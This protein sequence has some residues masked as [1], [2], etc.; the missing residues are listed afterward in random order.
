MKEEKEHTVEEE[1]TEGRQDFFMDK[2]QYKVSVQKPGFEGSLFRAEKYKLDKEEKN[3][4][5]LPKTAEDIS[6]TPLSERFPREKKE[7]ESNLVWKIQFINNCPFTV[8]IAILHYNEMCAIEGKRYE[9][10]SKGS[11][12]LWPWE[13]E[14][15]WKLEHGKVKIFSSLYPYFYY[16]AE[17]EEGHT[18]SG[19]VFTIVK[20]KAFSNCY[21]VPS[22]EAPEGWWYVGMREIYLYGYSLYKLPLWIGD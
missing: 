18:W 21:Y 22:G 7:I 8:Y 16:Y 17:D 11:G 1:E 20:E 5:M 3:A 12:Q 2:K 10:N 9:D 19:P 6:R 13:V 15:W 4:V 14:G